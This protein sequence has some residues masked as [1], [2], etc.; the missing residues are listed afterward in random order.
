MIYEFTYEIIVGGE[1][2]SKINM[3]AEIWSVGNRIEVGTLYIDNGFPSQRTEFKC[4]PEAH[5]LQYAL[6]NE[7]IEFLKNGDDAHDALF[8]DRKWNLCP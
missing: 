5:R 3:A 2:V 8:E 4:P 6:Y 1:V 7:V